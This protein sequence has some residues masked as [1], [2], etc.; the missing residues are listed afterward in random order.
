M[1]L[2]VVVKDTRTKNKYKYSVMKSWSDEELKTIMSVSF[3]KPIIFT[4]S[5]TAATKACHDL[6]EKSLSLT[7]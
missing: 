5:L 2:Y 7:N 6:N 1:E 4:E 3:W